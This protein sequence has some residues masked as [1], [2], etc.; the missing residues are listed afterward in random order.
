MADSI[1]YPEI[2]CK[3]NGI[4]RLTGKIAFGSSELASSSIEGATVTRLDAGE[5]KIALDETYV[6][7]QGCSII[8]NAN[9]TVPEQLE[10]MLFD[11]KPATDKWVKFW[12]LT[13]TV[14]TDPA[15]GREAY[16][17]LTFK[18]SGV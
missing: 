18:D 4:K 17:T 9:S 6:E 16:I 14:P 3:E 10:P 2:G 7:L 12:L 1:F 5:Y 15:S 13:G 8:V 11:V